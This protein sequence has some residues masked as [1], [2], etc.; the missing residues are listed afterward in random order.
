ATER[1]TDSNGLYRDILIPVTV[2]NANPAPEIEKAPADG[3]IGV[4]ADFESFVSDADNDLT[5]MSYLWSVEKDGQPYNLPAD[6]VVDQSTFQFAPDALG[7]YAITLQTT[8]KDKGV[9]SDS[10]NTVVN[11]DIA[12]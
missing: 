1:I 3:T 4:D 10:T 9:G 6:V 5:T 11:P 12:L 7:T 8:D 2:T